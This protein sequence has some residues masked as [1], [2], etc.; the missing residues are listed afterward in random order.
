[1]IFT[2]TVPGEP[3]GKARPKVNT[4]TRSAYTPKKTRTYE[5]KIKGCYSLQGGVK[6][7]GAVRVRII[8]FF[9]I[10]KSYTKKKRELIEA[11]KLLPTK[12]PDGDNIAKA[13]FDALNGVAYD[14]DKQI[15]SYEVM[16]RYAYGGRKTECLVITLEEDIPYGY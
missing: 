16:K 5:A 9:K 2:F 10:P 1:M 6:Y 12:K 14:D 13:V 7:E 8:A 15:T 3:E 11:G 4:V